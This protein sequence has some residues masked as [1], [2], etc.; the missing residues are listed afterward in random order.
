MWLDSILSMFTVEYFYATIRIASPLILAAIGEVYLERS[1]IFNL[2]LEAMMLIGA[3]FGVLGA[4]LSGSTPVGLLIAIIAST[5]IGL[6]F[7]FLVITLRADQIV[8]GAALN[9]AALGLTSFLSRIIFGIRE[10]PLQVTP[11]EEWAVP[12]LSDIP[13]LGRVLFQQSPLVY[14]VYLLVPLSTF[15]LFRTTWGLR[16][17][18]VGED[19]RTADTVGINVYGW[20]YACALLCGALCGLAGASL[21]LAQLNMFVDNMTAGRGFIALAA[22]IFGRWNPAGVVLASLV[23]GAADALQLRIQAFGVPIS[24]QLLLMA[25]YA[26]TLLGVMI[27]RGQAAAPA[28][29]TKPY[30]KETTS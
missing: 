27:F 15:V 16:I 8:T 18:S 3:F 29:L 10:Q 4:A 14:L 7:G 28:A 6:L 1:G 23:F 21:S 5:L 13:F 9:I 24:N 19:P 17:R 25:P 20:R 11:I 22:V 30:S 26:L 2:G 12:V